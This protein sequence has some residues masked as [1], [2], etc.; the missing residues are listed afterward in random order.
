MGDDQGG[1]MGIGEIARCQR[2][3]TQQTVQMH[4]QRQAAGPLA[5]M[6]KIEVEELRMAR[7]LLI[8]QRKN[9][10][11]KQSHCLL[12]KCLLIKSPGGFA[13][14]LESA[15]LAVTQVDNNLPHQQI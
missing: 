14:A 6:Q 15:V 7:A 3:A 9:K 11:K 2:L 12:I 5:A 1:Q 13:R 8:G 10:G 4:P